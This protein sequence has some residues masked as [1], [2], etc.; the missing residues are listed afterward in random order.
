[1]RMC[2]WSANLVSFLSSQPSSHVPTSVFIPPESFSFI[3]FSLSL[4]PCKKKLWVR[5]KKNSN[6]DQR[7]FIIA[8]HHKGLQAYINKDR[9]TGKKLSASINVIIMMIF[10]LKKLFFRAGDFWCWKIT[11]ERTHISTARSHNA[12]AAKWSAFTIH[13]LVRS[14]CS[15]RT[16]CCCDL[17]QGNYILTCVDGG[18]IHQAEQHR[19]W[20]IIRFTAVLA[21]SYEDK[22][23]DAVGGT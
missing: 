7:D 9:V 16:I 23:C 12:T 1:M 19:Y 3:P 17:S 18:C 10:Q 6:E 5:V 8:H 21:V 2:I 14:P 20:E 4:S 11:R 22:W 15:S 13:G